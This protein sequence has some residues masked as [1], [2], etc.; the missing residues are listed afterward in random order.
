MVELLVGSGAA[1]Q[2]LAELL[3]G[4]G[5]RQVDDRSLVSTFREI[6]GARCLCVEQRRGRQDRRRGLLEVRVCSV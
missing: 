4:G 6:D 3:I 5:D 1:A 2:E